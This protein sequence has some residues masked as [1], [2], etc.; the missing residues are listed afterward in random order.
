MSNIADAHDYR[1]V[2]KSVPDEAVE[3]VVQEFMLLFPLEAVSARQIAL[4]A[5]ILLIDKLTAQQARNVES[6]LGF[7]RR[8]G[9]EIG[10]TSDP[11]PALKRMTLPVKPDIVRR[12]ANVF[13][14]P[15]CGDRLVIEPLRSGRAAGTARA[16]ADAATVQ[17]APRPADADPAVVESAANTPKIRKAAPPP[18]DDARP[19]QP[20]EPEK[21][22]ESDILILDDDDEEKIEM[23][24]SPPE[25]EPEVDDGPR[26]LG[27][28]DEP[29]PPDPDEGEPVSDVGTCRVSVV[30]KLK[31][32][33][34][35]GAAE[36]IARYQGISL[37]EAIKETEKSFIT[38]ARNITR[39]Q[40][41]ECKRECKTLGIAV[42]ISKR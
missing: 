15:T 31:F 2:L 39:E 32:Q 9:A 4:A 23:P 11:L 13:I 10:I 5:P 3:G 27:P 37:E 22:E 30:R 28:D 20:P 36:L 12:P 7:L 42:T 16:R 29:E 41:K 26:I 40:A 19:N 34:K 25:L 33:H 38:I 35:K 17:P 21:L 6:H 14:C 24:K 18:P 1:L 8:L